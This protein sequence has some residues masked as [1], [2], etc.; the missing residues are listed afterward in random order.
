MKKLV[1]LGDS[2]RL[3]GYGQ[4]V[5]E[6]L[7]DEFEVWQPTDNC[8]FAAY[9][10]RMC[11]EEEEKFKNAD[12]I[13]FNCGLWD[14]CDLFGDGVFTSLDNYIAT[15]VRLVKVFRSLSPQATLIF[16]TTTPTMPQFPRQDVE[17]IKAYNKAVVEALTPMG[18]LIDDL[19]PTVYADMDAMICGD[20]VHLSEYGKDV[21]SKQVADFIRASQK[22]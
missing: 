13:H 1:L 8:R 22:A 3:I 7:S 19:F 6:R 14:T 12:V 21:L 5:A 9:T 10:L 4:Q 20:L 2:I 11:F 15:M 18:V 16:A 17:R